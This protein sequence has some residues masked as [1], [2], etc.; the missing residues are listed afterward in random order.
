LRR[1]AFPIALAVLLGPRIAD[2]S[3]Q[4]EEGSGEEEVLT[5]EPDSADDAEDTTTDDAEASSD[6]DS[7]G[8][9]A[10]AEAGGSAS[11]STADAAP[12][13]GE[14]RM[15][16]PQGAL[17]IQ[18]FLQVNMSADLV[19]K[20]VSLAP[21]I[22]YGVNDD[23]TI[24]LIHSGQAGSGVWGGV[25]QGLCLTGEEN[26]CA[27]LYNSVGLDVRYHIY[28]SGGMTAAIDGGLFA[29]TID[30][31]ALALKLGLTGRWQ[32]GALGLEF[33]PN[34]GIG[35]T[36]RGGETAEGVEVEV[37]GNKEVFVLPVNLLYGL[38][39]SFGILAQVAATLPF[40]ALGDTYT[41][42]ASAGVK[43]MVSQ[44]LG[45]DLAFSLPFIAGGAD[46]AGADLRT[47][48]LGVSYAL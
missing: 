37:V 32:G 27:K 6:D 3:A 46:G 29:R 9:E 17:L 45:V 1:V 23:L 14:L 47:L 11:L 18:A 13:S 10:S 5:E 7:S 21:D 26:G 30:P 28:S 38:S 36:E 33:G 15:T 12:G 43:Y 25:G 40:D 4:E 2:V 34:V 48:T 24:G 42:G 20:P 31:F 16:L 39:D 35:L 41:I 8:A 19:A 44:Q 22:W